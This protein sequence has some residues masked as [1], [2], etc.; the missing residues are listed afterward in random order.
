MQDE[1]Q[2]LAQR[3]VTCDA[4]ESARR[5]RDAQTQGSDHALLFQARI[6]EMTRQVLWIDEALPR[7]Q[8]LTR[9][10]RAARAATTNAARQQYEAR[11]YEA[12]RT[13]QIR[14][15]AL[16]F[17]VL[18]GLLL[19]VSALGSPLWWV[20]VGGV[21]S[22]VLAVAGFVWSL[23]WQDALVDTC[24]AS[25]DQ[26][27]GVL[28]ELL[29]QRDAMLRGREQATAERTSPLDAVSELP[30]ADRMRALNPQQLT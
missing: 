12:Y 23:W 15:W 6:D 9:R 16:G 21:V 3:R 1:H 29:V 17:G 27:Q 18:A 30:P 22:A 19:V 5:L 7:L 26:A 2:L 25:L 10:L 8:D 20:V 14:R 11:E 24:Q 13:G 4:I 28:D